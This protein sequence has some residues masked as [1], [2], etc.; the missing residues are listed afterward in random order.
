V[1]R[2]SDLQLSQSARL[3]HDRERSLPSS[4]CRECP[5]QL[6][7]IV[8]GAYTPVFAKHSKDSVAIGSDRMQRDIGPLKRHVAE[9][10]AMSKS[11]LPMPRSFCKINQESTS[12]QPSF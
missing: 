5:R 12:N 4:A 2:F 10:Q 11:G 1:P 7:N 6:G 9:W 8:A 3:S